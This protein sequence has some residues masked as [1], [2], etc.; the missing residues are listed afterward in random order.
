MLIGL[1][2]DRAH[3]QRFSFTIGSRLFAQ[4]ETLGMATHQVSVSE[5]QNALFGHPTG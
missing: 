4:L 5:V 3:L 2:R 1:L